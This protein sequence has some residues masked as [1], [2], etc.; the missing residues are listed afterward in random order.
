MEYRVNEETGEVEEN[1]ADM[2]NDLIEKKMFEVGAIDKETFEMISMYLYYEQQIDLLKYKLQK[3]MEEN[4]IKKWDND[5]FTATLTEETLRKS[6]DTQKLKDDGLYE[7]YL[8]L[9]HIKAGIRIK[10]K[11]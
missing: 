11:D 6:V 1:Q 3:A 8:K 4:G 2:R 10:F 7:K 5:Y 9:S